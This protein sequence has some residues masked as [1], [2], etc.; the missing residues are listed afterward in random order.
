MHYSIGLTLLDLYEDFFDKIFGFAI[1]KYVEY[2][3]EKNYMRFVFYV[4]TGIVF[5][6]IGCHKKNNTPAASSNNTISTTTSNLKITLTSDKSIIRL[7]DVAVI[8]ASVQG[9]CGN[10]NYRWKVNTIAGLQGTGNT[11]TLTPCCASVA[12][13]NI[14]ECSVTDSKNNFCKEQISVIVA[15]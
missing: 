1:I 10:L 4:I 14:I 15:P 2:I 3:C 9:G 12:G 13:D 7:G 8:T 11:V 5:I 6:F